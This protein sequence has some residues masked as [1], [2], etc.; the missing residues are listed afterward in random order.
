MNQYAYYGNDVVQKSLRGYRLK[1]LK[2]T[3][4][5][6]D[7][8]LRLLSFLRSASDIRKKLIFIL[9]KCVFL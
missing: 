1:Y 6:K 7:D 4:R 3:N 2:C 8:C 5:Y 9:I